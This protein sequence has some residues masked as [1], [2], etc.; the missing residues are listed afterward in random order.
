MKKMTK[1][2]FK[3]Q[4]VRYHEDKSG[5]V[6]SGIFVSDVYAIDIERDSFLVYDPG[7]GCPDDDYFYIPEGFT[8]VNYLQTMQK[9]G[10]AEGQREMVVKLVD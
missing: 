9:L 3:V 4:V 5:Y 2:G 10:G 8:W 7:E 6:C 1:E